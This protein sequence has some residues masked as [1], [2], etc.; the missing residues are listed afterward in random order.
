MPLPSFSAV[1]SVHCPSCLIALFV[2]ACA[3]P[4]SLFSWVWAPFSLALLFV[5]RALLLALLLGLR[6]LLLAVTLGRALLILRFGLALARAPLWRTLLLG[7]ALGLCGACF[8]FR[9]LLSDGRHGAHH[10]P[11]IA[12][13]ANRVWRCIIET[14]FRRR[15]AV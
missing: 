5:L 9:L 11:T 10:E 15:I 8:V 7:F 1:R 12:V 6:A 2:G 4:L 14:P 3:V 13:P